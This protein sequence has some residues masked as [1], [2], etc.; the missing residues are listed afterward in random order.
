M[1]NNE[2]VRVERNIQVFSKFNIEKPR[3]L[4]SMRTRSLITIQIP[5]SG[6]L[7]KRL[8]DANAPRGENG[9]LRCA[10]CEVTMPSAQVAQTHFSGK[11]HQKKLEAIK[12]AEETEEEIFHDSPCDVLVPGKEEEEE[13]EEE[14]TEEEIFQDLPCDVLVPGKEE[15]EEEEAM[16]E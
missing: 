2:S 11:K 15:E 3:V 16:Q 1:S 6:R 5:T 13:E 10:L 12:M 4:S 7:V 8:I 9:K 14:E